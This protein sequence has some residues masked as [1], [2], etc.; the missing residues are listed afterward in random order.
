MALHFTEPFFALAKQRG[1]IVH[2]VLHDRAIKE[3]YNE[4]AGGLDIADYDAHPYGN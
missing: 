3:E 1:H 4:M 2:E